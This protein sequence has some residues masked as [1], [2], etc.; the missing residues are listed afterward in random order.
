MTLISV[1]SRMEVRYAA[2]ILACLGS[3]TTESVLPVE[4]NAAADP[5]PDDGI[6]AVEAEGA[7]TARDAAEDE[8]WPC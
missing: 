6:P 4:P 1:L 7:T 5:E 2:G 8:D 3:T